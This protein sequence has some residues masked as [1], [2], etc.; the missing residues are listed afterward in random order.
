M[1]SQIT[2][3]LDKIIPDKKVDVS[4]SELNLYPKLEKK[5]F[6]FSVKINI[7]SHMLKKYNQMK[8]GEIAEIE[9]DLSLIEI[10]PDEKIDLSLEILNR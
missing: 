8:K 9:K 3:F 1:A 10:E 4:A 2:L 5:T 7:N 6:H